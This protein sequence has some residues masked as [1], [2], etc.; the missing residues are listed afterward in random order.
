VKRSFGGKR[1]YSLGK[2]MM[3]LKK[4]PSLNKKKGSQKAEAISPLAGNILK[5]EKL[6]LTACP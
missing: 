1:G 4:P 5:Q 2:V 6:A 3:A